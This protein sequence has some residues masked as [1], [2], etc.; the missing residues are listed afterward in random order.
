MKSITSL[1]RAE[2]E[3]EQQ[4]PFL[5]ESNCYCPLSPLQRLYGFGGC[6]VAAFLC[7]L[8]DKQN[9]RDIEITFSNINPSIPNMRDSQ[10][11]TINNFNT[12][13]P[14]IRRKS[15][16]AFARPVKFAIIFSFGNLLAI[17][18]TA[19]VI[20]LARQVRMMFD[21]VRIYATSI[22]IGSVVLALVC[23]LCF[24]NKILTILAIIIEI[25]ALIWYSLSYIPFARRMVSQLIVS[26]GDTEI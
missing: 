15:L 10:L 13:I 21:P 2:E 8:L 7:M 25:C 24:H 5:D 26:C 3:E 14:R 22:Y 12:I 11:N 16:V 23:A 1:L 17:G 18:S 4:D 6:L 19:F 9:V 20:G